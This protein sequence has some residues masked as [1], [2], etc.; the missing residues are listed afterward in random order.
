MVSL[1]KC[2]VSHGQQHH[3]MG[4]RKTQAD[5][6]TLRLILPSAV[7]D[8]RDLSLH[9]L[10]WLSFPDTGHDD[11][12]GG[13]L[14]FW[15]WSF[16]WIMRQVHGEHNPQAKDHALLRPDVSTV[17]PL[18][19]QPCSRSDSFSSLLLDLIERR[20]QRLLVAGEDY[21]AGNRDALGGPGNRSGSQKVP[22]WM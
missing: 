14:F 21:D 4:W 3:V 5:S 16:I 7:Q 22:P 11:G 9:K 15:T 12:R 6:G 13:L 8:K 1:S 2:Q 17:W 10:V 20:A 19:S 18:G